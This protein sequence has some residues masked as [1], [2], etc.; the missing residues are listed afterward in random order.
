[1][2]KNGS[3]SLPCSVKYVAATGYAA[4]LVD[5]Y[6]MPMSQR[7]YGDAALPDAER[8]AADIAR[9]IL[10]QRLDVVNASDIRRCWKLPGLR[11]VEKVKAALQTLEEAGWLWAAPSREGGQP[12]RQKTNFTVNPKVYGSLK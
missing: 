10:R 9:R 6:F 11:T 1:M 2:L 5:S 3:A 12:G 8:H 4:H 7:V